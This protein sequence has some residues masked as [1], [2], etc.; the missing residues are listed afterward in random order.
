VYQTAFVT[1]ETG[2]KY[3]SVPKCLVTVRRKAAE[4]LRFKVSFNYINADILERKKK[5]KIL[6][7]YQRQKISNDSISAKKS[8]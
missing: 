8:F 1:P 7:E 3:L 6:R 5:K 4:L 2:I